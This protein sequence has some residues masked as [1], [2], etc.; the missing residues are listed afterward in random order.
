MA[1]QANGADTT[2]KTNV[3]SVEA[4]EV[5]QIEQQ[6]QPVVTLPNG[7]VLM[8]EDLFLISAPT[9]RQY[10]DTKKN[11][12]ERHTFA[13]QDYFLFPVNGKV[14][15]TRDK[16]FAGA[17][18]LGDLYS[19]TIGERVVGSAV[20][21]ELLGYV[22]KTQKMAQ[23]K[24]DDEVAISKARIKRLDAYDPKATVDADLM[25]SL[26]AGV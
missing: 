2:A 1:N 10:P 26:L 4:I 13:G 20:Y 22:T 8:G 7:G 23:I 12:T 14:F 6:A 16:N 17:H 21:F 3:I 5:P 18:K 24:F 19:V 25:N 15:T 11:S 9:V